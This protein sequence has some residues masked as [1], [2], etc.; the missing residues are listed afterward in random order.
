M[1]G[2]ESGAWWFYYKLGFQSHDR[3][4]LRVLKGELARMKRNPKH[5]SSIDTLSELTAE[6][7][8]FYLDRPRKDV[9]G[10]IALGEIGLKVVRYLAERFGSD[11]EKAV[12]VCSKEAAKLTGL[13]SL[14]G[15]TAG[16]KLAW[17]RWSPLILSIPGVS[18]W[19]PG[20]KK[21]LVQVVRAKGG[22]RE[23]EFV[24]LFDSHTKLRNAVLK[25]SGRR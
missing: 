10:R 8:F 1:E 12:E 6:H 21:A 24:W 7:M 11:R 15:F 25:M 16:E 3:E 4:V 19:T 9:I 17:E 2:L 5:R 20:E 13:R 14:S 23:S 22:Q 18:R